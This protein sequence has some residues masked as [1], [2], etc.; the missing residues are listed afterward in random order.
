MNKG[1]IKAALD[2][3][4]SIQILA[5]GTSSHTCT[6]CETPSSLIK[7]YPIA[8][9]VCLST[10]AR[11]ENGDNLKEDNKHTETTSTPKIPA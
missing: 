4:Q 1:I 3:M 2:P 6:E 11:L 5:T 9:S 7:N 10:S 8:E